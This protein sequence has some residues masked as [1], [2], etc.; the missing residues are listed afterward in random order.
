METLYKAFSQV[1]PEVEELFFQR[2]AILKQL[3]HE[4]QRIGRQALSQK[5]GFTERMIRSN[6]E[7][8]RD[9]GLVDITSAGIAITDQGRRIL[10]QVGGYLTDTEELRL[11]ANKVKT[12]L[13]VEHCLVVPGSLKESEEVAIA[14]ASVVQEVL[15]EHLSQGRHIIAVTGGETLSKV[16]SNLTPD[17]SRGRDIYFVPARGGMEGTFDIQS[18]SVGAVMAR[19]TRS[20]Y[21]PLFIPENI[22]TQTT[23]ALLEDPS[24]RQV[25]EMVQEAECLLVSVG[26]AEVMAERREVTFTQKQQ[27]REGHAVGEVF[28]VF[29]DKKGQEIVRVPRAGLQLEDMKKI[30]LL[31]TIVGGK[32]KA[33]AVTAYYKLIDRHG[34]LICDEQLAQEVLSLQLYN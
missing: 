16:A 20:K 30:P 21:V 15:M 25:V 24:I 7:Q 34:W 31:L 28:G 5:V 17:L 14:F 2:L 18:N 9:Q 11:L 4:T 6:I 32:A 1:V 22:D 13:G 8:L 33:E 3:T 10:H 26:T 12:H 19:E 23:N 27:I 29:F